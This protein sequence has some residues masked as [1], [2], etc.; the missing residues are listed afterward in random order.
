[1]TKKTKTII[2]CVAGVFVLGALCNSCTN[3][4]TSTTQTAT[5]QET[6]SSNV[7]MNAKLK[8]EDVKSGTGDVIGKRAYI[9]IKKDQLTALTMDEFKEFA[10][11]VVKDSG[12]NY[13][14]I[15][16]DDASKGI[17]FPGSMVEIA[18]YGIVDVNGTLKT[19]IG[20]IQLQDD[21]NYVYT[22]K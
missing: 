19:V 17:F 4:N 5:I 18:Q 22:A 11:S 16:A 20:Y 10:N 1:M 12:Y 14:T 6:A 15:I 9:E 8:T 2:G 3:S 13:V 7:L 21:G